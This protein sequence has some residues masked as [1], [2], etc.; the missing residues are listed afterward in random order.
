MGPRSGFIYLG[1]FVLSQVLI[2]TFALGFAVLQRWFPRP[3]K[4]WWP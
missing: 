3:M 1:M 4:N 2:A